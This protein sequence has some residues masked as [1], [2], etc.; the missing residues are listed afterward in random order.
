MPNNQP[1]MKVTY[2]SDSSKFVAGT[3]QAKTAVRDFQKTTEQAMGQ[4]GEAFGV[5][6][7]K[8]GQMTS[9]VKGLG[10]ELSK[11]GNAGVKAFGE[12][13]SG[14]D[15]VKLGIAGLG[16]GAA[17]ASFKALQATAENFKKTVAGANIEMATAA[18]VSTYQQ[19]FYDMNTAQGKAMA[20]FM[21]GL[22]KIKAGAG[23]VLG[24]F[25]VNQGNSVSTAL[26]GIADPKFWKDTIG[27]MKNA[28]A[29]ATKASDIANQIYQLERQRSNMMVDLAGK[30]NRIAELKNIIWDKTNSTVERSEALAEAQQ[31]IEEKYRS[32]IDIE[33]AI[34]D[35]ME[36]QN[37][38]ASS[39]PEQIDRANQQ[40]VKAVNLESQMNN[41]QRSLLRQQNSLTSATHASTE[42]LKE[43][44]RQLELVRKAIAEGIDQD[45]AGRPEL[46]NL[47]VS[48]ISMPGAT[49]NASIALAGYTGQVEQ[50]SKAMI[51]LK[52][53]LTDLAAD[54]AVAIGSLIGDLINGE[55]AWGNFGNAALGALGD[56]AVAVGKTIMQEGIAV[57]AAKMALTT[58]SGIGAIA[59]GAALVAI[60]S[61]L[62]TS[63]KNAASG[64]YS[65]SGGV[66]S[67]SYGRGSS[68]GSREYQERGFNVEVTG[69]LI[70]QGNQLVAVIQQENNRKSHTT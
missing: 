16:L 48:G 2:T 25:L 3:R 23:A 58:M 10:V 66:A 7:G 5:N 42:A 69:Q 18:Y 65:A 26:L 12:M 30:E 56:M 11:S 46:Y 13:V 61:A 34:A 68:A 59:A 70:G 27:A 9:S 33:T 40:R 64:N 55:N 29:V 21:S 28:N 19:A 24:N 54:G 31:L 36:Q 37:S 45:I 60:G 20:N 62:K 39:T 22:E 17:I 67:S 44:L 63:L 49:T 50:I 51:D 53:S 1:N 43:Q 8:L 14:L 47:G 52:A 41:E 35:L 4:L 32:Q 38:L 6:T 15:A 57:E